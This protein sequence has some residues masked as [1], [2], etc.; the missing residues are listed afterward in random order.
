MPSLFKYLF[1]ELPAIDGH[2]FILS[3]HLG[4]LSF[5]LQET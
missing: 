4:G 3:R 5:F 1:F 2:D